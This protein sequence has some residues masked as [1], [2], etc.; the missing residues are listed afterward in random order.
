MSRPRALVALSGGVDSAVAA[1]LLLDQGFE[2]AGATLWLWGSDAGAPPSI[3]RAAAVAEALGI[4]LETVDARAEFEAWV[5]G[6]FVADYGAGRTPNPCIRCNQHI[7]FGLLLRHAQAIGAQWLATGHYART[8]TLDGHELL[9]RGRD[10]RK[11]QSYF[12][13]RLNQAQLAQ[14]RFPLGA[15]TKEQVRQMARERGLPSAAQPESQDICFLAGGDYRAF[16]ARR[17]PQL[18]RPGP[19][20][21]LDGR[22]VGQH[23]GLP[24]YTIGQRSG[25][26]IAAR[27]PLYVVAI[28][29]RENALVVGPARALG[30]DCCVVEELHLVSGEV[31]SAPFEAHAQIRYRA[32]PTPVRVVPTGEWQAVVEFARVQR[33]ITPGQSLVLYDGEV[34]LGGGIICATAEA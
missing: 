8:R 4:P 7:K 2:V 9:L 24:G 17:A 19:I 5:L 15:L 31:P 23:R 32:E 34:V 13:Y 22:V 21:D 11:D 20:R 10:R 1:A 14:V 16:L 6:S 28:D 25:L 29:A 3:G 27:E 12:L 26:G 30:R 33:D 18:F